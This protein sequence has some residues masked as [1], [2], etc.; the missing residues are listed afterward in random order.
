[1]TLAGTYPLKS[2]RVSAGCVGNWRSPLGDQN[3]LT[4][5]QSHN[6]ASAQIL[7]NDF[8]VLEIGLETS[9]A[10]LYFSRLSKL[11]LSLLQG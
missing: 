10:N 5:V 2:L 9:R 7:Y 3:A 1:L 4:N 8:W 11:N 6:S